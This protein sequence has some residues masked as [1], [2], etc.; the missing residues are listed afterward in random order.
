MFPTGI[1]AGVLNGCS[2]STLL[3]EPPTN[4]HLVM[5][6]CDEGYSGGVGTYVVFEREARTNFFTFSPECQ[7]FHFYHLYHSFISEEKSL[8]HA[9][10]K[11]TIKCYVVFEREYHTH[12]SRELI[13]YIT[14]NTQTT[15]K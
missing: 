2:T 9:T 12:V 10:L 13:A 11:R 5:S 6:K 15:L 4:P 14:Q 7:F 1:V 3:S 8:E